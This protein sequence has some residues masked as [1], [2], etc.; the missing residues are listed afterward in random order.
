MFAPLP[1]GTLFSCAFV[2]DL[3]L[4]EPVLRQQASFRSLP[5]S[6]ASPHVPKNLPEVTVRLAR[7]GVNRDSKGYGQVH[8]EI[9]HTGQKAELRGRR[10]SGCL[11]MRGATRLP[12][13]LVG[14][15]EPW[16]LGVGAA[17]G[18]WQHL[19]QCLAGGPRTELGVWHHLI[20]P[21]P[22]SEPP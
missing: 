14:V 1:Q 20:V 15:S 12:S 9:G 10:E 21:S 6:K 18:L 8:G 17:L 19:Q 3:L 22:V 7:R 2:W 5:T 11:R 4:R 16:G 13:C